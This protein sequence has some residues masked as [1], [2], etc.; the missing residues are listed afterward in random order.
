MDKKFRFLLIDDSEEVLTKLRSQIRT[1]IQAS[2]FTFGLEVEYL[3]VKFDT[4]DINGV[5]TKVV[6]KQTIVSLGDM[7]REKFHYIFSDFAFISD[8]EANTKLKEQLLRDQR[9]VR[10]SDI[11]GVLLTLEDIKKRYLEIQK[12]TDFPQMKITLIDAH[13]IN[14]SGKVV[15]YTNSPAPFD[16]Y[17]DENEIGERELEVKR[18]FENLSKIDFILMHKKFLIT[19]K[20]EATFTDTF[21]K[22][23]YFATLL[24][25]YITNEME[26]FTLE[27]MVA[28]QNTL[29]FKNV[30]KGA[31]EIFI[32]GLALGA[33][34]ALLGEMLFHFLSRP[35][36]LILEYFGIHIKESIIGSLAIFVILLIGCFYLLTGLAGK[37]A[38]RTEEITNRLSGDDEK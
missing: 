14:H 33:M 11:E 13:F 28:S 31:R 5:A 17:F 37:L 29:R 21:E 26:Y 24:S 32:L 3:H 16:N 9:G 25:K 38:K 7:C 34:S 10:R 18:A 8:Y 27:H 23:I 6:S 19:P 4:V 2:Q 12:D 20:I 15:L 30:R 36:E 35:I 22:K 1:T